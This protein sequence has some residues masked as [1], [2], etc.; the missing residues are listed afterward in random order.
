M[1]PRLLHSY[2]K[3]HPKHTVKM[4]IDWLKGIKK[5]DDKVITFING[6]FCEVLK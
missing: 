5:E 2:S 6:R 1:S 3:K 4:F